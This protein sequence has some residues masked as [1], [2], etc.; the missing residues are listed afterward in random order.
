MSAPLD[1]QAGQQAKVAALQAAFSR[2]P[3]GTRARA[4]DPVTGSALRDTLVL[5]AA[6]D[7]SA[8]YECVIIAGE[9]DA[10]GHWLLDAEFTIFTTDVEP[11]GELILCHG[12]N[13]HAELQ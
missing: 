1:D 11:S 5:V 4:T 13:C 6:A 8:A 7:G 12:W 2:L 3:A 9:R 10:E